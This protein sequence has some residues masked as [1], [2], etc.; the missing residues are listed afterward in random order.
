[1]NWFMVFYQLQ[2]FLQLHGVKRAIPKPDR[3]LASAAGWFYEA[4]HVIIG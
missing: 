3:M 2:I 1:M 4:L